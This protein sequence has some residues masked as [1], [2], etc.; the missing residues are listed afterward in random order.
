MPP[1]SPLAAGGKCERWQGDLQGPGGF[2]EQPEGRL[3]REEV[4][5]CEAGVAAGDDSVCPERQSLGGVPV[6]I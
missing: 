6:S 5:G 4:A 3:G 2:G 1:L